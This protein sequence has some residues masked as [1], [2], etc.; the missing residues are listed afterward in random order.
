M[1]QYFFEEHSIKVVIFHHENNIT[2]VELHTETTNQIPNTDIPRKAQTVERYIRKYLQ[3][4][5]KELPLEL[6]TPLRLPQFQEKILRVLRKEIPYG[7]TT[8]YGKLAE[9]AGHT[10]AARATGCALRGNPYPLFFPCHRVIRS[11]GKIGSFAGS[12]KNMILKK[13]LIDLE[14]S[15]KIQR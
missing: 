14:Q 7:T 10:G 6:I 5:I 11:D 9:Y 15:E 1:N 8:T 12:A 3:G 4:T 13:M 2:R